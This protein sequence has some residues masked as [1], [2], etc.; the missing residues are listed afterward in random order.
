MDQG[1]DTDLNVL[2]IEEFSQFN[3]FKIFKW[4]FELRKKLDLGMTRIFSQQ[5]EI[6][7]SINS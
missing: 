5:L 7:I 6:K 1:L 3:E 4:M 2:K